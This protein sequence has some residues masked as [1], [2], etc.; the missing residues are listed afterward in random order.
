ME[1]NSEIPQQPST[2]VETKNQPSEKPDYPFIRAADIIPT[3]DSYDK[4]EISRSL[5][6][7]VKPNTQPEHSQELK[8]A[9]GWYS[10]GEKEKGDK[11]ANQIPQ[12]EK[13]AA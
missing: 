11:I 12:T 3:H 10:L 6:D 8:T 13:L 5:Q 1:N 4:T 7:L 2:Q 9:L